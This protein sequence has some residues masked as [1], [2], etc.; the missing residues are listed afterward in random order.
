MSDHDRSTD[1][2]PRNGDTDGYAWYQAARA[3]APE[4]GDLPDDR[5]PDTQ[6]DV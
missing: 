2:G 5:A 4:W 6:D 1:Y 3:N